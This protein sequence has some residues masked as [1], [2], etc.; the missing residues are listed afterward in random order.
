[1]AAQEKK[2]VKKDS[3]IDPIYKKFTKS[4]RRAI[5][6][7]EFYEFFMDAMSR[8]EN[9]FQFSNRR[10]EKI[11]DVRWVEAIEASINAMQLIV[12]S[13]RNI[14]REDELI[15]NIA[16]AK[17]AG[18]DVVRHLAQHGQLVED[19]NPDTGDVRPSKL[20][21]KFREDS[22]DLYE[23]R[24][25][26]TTIEMAHHFVEV[27]YNAL[28]EAM[29][30]EF[31][32]KL[33]TSTNLETA[34]E[35]IHFDTFMHVKTKDSALDVDEKN[36]DI[37][38]RIDRL[39]RLLTVFMNTAY[40]QQM[41]KL[42]RVRG[43]LTKTNILKKNPSYRKICDLYDFLRRYDDVG[44]AIKITE[45][46]PQLTE[47]F[48]EDIFHNTL[49]QYVVLK[50]YLEN[51]E[52]RLLPAPMKQKKR[53]LRPKVIKEI[54][55]ELTDDYDIPDLEIRKVLIEELT[56]EQLMLEEAEERRRLVQ[57]AEERK[58]L[59]EELRQKIL[60]EEEEKRQ[61]EAEAEAER[62]RLEEEERNR[63][64][65]VRELEQKLDDERRKMIFNEELL[66][67]T[68]KLYDH[69]DQ[70]SQL[71][72][73]M[74]T[75]EPVEDPLEVAIALAEKERAE[76]QA[77]IEREEAER[78]AKEEA[79]RLEREAR[80][81]EE[82]RI[83]EEEERRLYEEEQERIRI[84]RAEEAEAER[85]RVLEETKQKAADVSAVNP[86]MMEIRYFQVQ[87]AARRQKRVQLIED[88]KKHQEILM[89]ER[90]MREAQRTKKRGLWG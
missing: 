81:A 71:A 47:Q 58:R 50:G 56:K 48:V 26:Y 36:G 54:I 87:L 84:L 13:P 34:V 3:L 63:I 8:A 83:R 49:F 75:I 38:S 18:S 39:H 67:F 43:N 25:V 52:D 19:F 1:M 24:L 40:A 59:E 41:S 15:V 76:I 7:T 85:V 17:K 45:Q 89:K 64:E 62:L 5:G 44:Y 60:Q 22:E 23:N 78:K 37:L 33:K 70:R 51:E 16:N 42:N 10:M 69:L 74:K 53:K 9:E 77:E 4:V 55:E 35:L 82:R 90:L 21:Q 73:S 29:G 80:E 68:D 12:A 31:G 6:S 65:K 86:Y 72:E 88:E 28:F 27:R 11:V 57:E 61:R 66:Y 30:D 32:A 20:M 2:T 14:I 46:N 79:E